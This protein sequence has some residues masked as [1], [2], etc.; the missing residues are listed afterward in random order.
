METTTVNWLCPRCDLRIEAPT[1]EQA[2]HLR[3][4]HVKD[5]H[6]DD[7]HEVEGHL[8]AP[9]QMIDEHLHY[10][11]QDIAWVACRLCGDRQEI[12]VSP[13]IYPDFAD[14]AAAVEA[15][16]DVFTRKHVYRHQHD[17]AANQPPLP[18]NPFE[19]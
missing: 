14:A 13:A 15:V 11:D 18:E 16:A 7:L 8:I 1:R 12:P 9:V 17:L 10:G 3:Y 19:E 6:P 5:K 2:E 4:E